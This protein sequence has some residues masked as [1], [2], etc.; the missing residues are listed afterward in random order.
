MAV[1][2]ASGRIA[3]AYSTAKVTLTADPDRFIR[4]QG[5]TRRLWLTQMVSG[6]ALPCLLLLFPVALYPTVHPISTAAL[7]CGLLAAASGFTLA[8]NGQLECA[9]LVLIAGATAAITIAIVGIGYF[10]NGLDVS[11]IGLLDWY[12]VPTVLATLLLRRQFALAVTATCSLAMVLELF[13]L[14]RTS[15]LEAFWQHR[16]PY[17]QSVALDLFLLPLALNWLV[18]AV[19]LVA[20]AAV[21]R[22]MLQ[23][24][25]ADAL[26]AAN[27]RIAA[28]QREL[29]TLR[30]H[31]QAN[32]RQI[33][34]V[35]AAAQRGNLA[36]RVHSPAPELLPVALSFNLLLDRIARLTQENATY[37]ATLD[38]Q[39]GT[40]NTEGRR[41]YTESRGGGKTGSTV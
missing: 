12:I 32:A 36:V 25:Q 38:S 15:T 24:V 28:Q 33:Q 16:A 11:H 13:V 40:G 18:T 3:G 26:S 30:E 5:R 10:G 37:R 23:A 41:G 17:T 21:R 31:L 8:R 20:A 34:S 35:S 9:A 6:A 7:L 14:P 1:A 39:R 27:E 19:T 2:S 29:A 22:G 4:Q